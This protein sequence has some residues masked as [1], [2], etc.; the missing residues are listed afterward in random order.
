MSSAQV[1]LTMLLVAAAGLCLARGVV[2]DD[3]PAAAP[4]GA[5]AAAPNVAGAA[6]AA[7]AAAPGL[8]P[9]NKEQTVW[10]D[11]ANRRLVLKA[12][13]VLRQGLLE[14]LL[15]KR[16]TKEHEAILAIQGD[17]YVIHAGL[18]AL[19]AQSGTPVRYQP[20]FRP[21]TGQA[22][23]IVLR[24]TDAE[25]KPREALAQSWVRHAI[26]R[27]FSHPLAKLPDGFVLPKAS[28]LR[29]DEVNQHLVWFGP[30]TAA[31]RDEL[32]ALSGERD[33]QAGIRQFF[34]SSQP[35]ELEAG[36]VFA[37]S[38][39]YDLGDGTRRYQ[40][41]DGNVICVAN[42][43][44]ALLDLSIASSAS[45]DGLM[46]EPYTERLPPLGTP[47]E[48]D[49]IPVFEPAA[50]GPPGSNAAPSTPAAAPPAPNRPTD[51]NRST[52][53]NRSTDPSPE[54]DMPRP[55]DR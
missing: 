50:G 46:F 22:I 1:T 11:K 30:M 53:S 13:V 20:T 40:A 4:S 45:N 48:V 36:W 17:A 41:E 28:E 52:D 31:Q 39:F 54:T 16:H 44:D 10:I 37:G 19:G 14:M 6:A 51:P 29:Y 5:G 2:A 26:L 55:P 43:G 15:C 32:L 42:F 7:G 24:W 25:G 12:E 18:L 3:A 9:L 49:L 23:K 8:V 47:V 33:Y 34:A 35:R 38:G 27:Y 21:P